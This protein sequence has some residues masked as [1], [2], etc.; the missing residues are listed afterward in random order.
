VC[1]RSSAS[2]RPVLPDQGTLRIRVTSRADSRVIT[3]VSR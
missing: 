3:A 2:A 1:H